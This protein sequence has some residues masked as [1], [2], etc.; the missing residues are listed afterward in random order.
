MCRSFRKATWDCR[1]PSHF[2]GGTGRLNHASPAFYSEKM[3]LHVGFCPVCSSLS[4]RAAKT[5]RAASLSTTVPPLLAANASQ[6]Q[7]ASQ[8]SF[9]ALNCV[10]RA[11]VPDVP[12]FIHDRS[13]AKTAGRELIL[14][15]SVRSH[16]SEEKA[17][18]R[19]PP[20]QLPRPSG[21]HPRCKAAAER[22]LPG[23]SGH[24]RGVRVKRPKGVPRDA[25]HLKATSTRWPSHAS[26][27]TM[28]L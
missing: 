24:S 14:S 13:A 7:P 11:C 9:F 8:V 5:S 26:A 15:P 22:Q 1:E 23:C 17:G 21:E 16:R 25:T 20:P 27:V 3:R 2:G 19:R 4:P 18:G 12:T 10:P 6:S 28:E